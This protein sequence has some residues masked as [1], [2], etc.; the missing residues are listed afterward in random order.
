MTTLN[1]AQVVG[2]SMM[3]VATGAVAAA[4][5]DARGDVPPDAYRAMFALIG[6]CLAAGLALYARGPDARPRPPAR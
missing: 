2:A 4:F 1:L 5:T 3:P 6:G